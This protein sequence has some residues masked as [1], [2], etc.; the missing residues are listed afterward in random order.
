MGR[1]NAEWG[2]ANVDRGTKKMGSIDAETV[3]TKTNEAIF[4]MQNRVFDP[5]GVVFGF[6]L[7]NSFSHFEA[8]RPIT[9]YELPMTS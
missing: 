5:A 7:V 6:V 8:L 3:K 2:T 4:G 1:A 9:K